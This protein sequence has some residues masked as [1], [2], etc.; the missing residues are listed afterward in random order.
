MRLTASIV[1][2]RD[3]LDVALHEPLEAVADADDLDAFERGRGW[4]RR[5]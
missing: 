1:E 4:W 5:R 3:V 2:R